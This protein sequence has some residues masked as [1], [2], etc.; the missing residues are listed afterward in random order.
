MPRKPTAND[1]QQGL[2]GDKEFKQWNVPLFDQ[3]ISGKYCLVYS[4]VSIKELEGAPESVRNLM[5]IIP[6]DN[7]ELIQS[8]KESNTLARAYI[9]SGALTSKS[10]ADAEHIAVASVH[11]V[12]AIISWN[13]KHMVNYDKIQHF[14]RI[15][16]RFKYPTIDI[17]QPKSFIL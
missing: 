8:N 14:N 9:E 13:F 17:L 12:D 5:D 7:K 15:N 6:N 10:L 11:V 2:G 1:A 16:H 4:D 3:A